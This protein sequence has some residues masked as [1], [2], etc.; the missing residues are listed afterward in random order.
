VRNKIQKRE[1]RR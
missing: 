1:H